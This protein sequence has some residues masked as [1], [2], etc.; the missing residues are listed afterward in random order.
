MACRASVARTVEFRPMGGLNGRSNQCVA[1][2]SDTLVCVPVDCPHRRSS[3]VRGRGGGRERRGGGR[4]SRDA[5]LRCC[6]CVPPPRPG[7][8]ACSSHARRGFRLVERRWTV[9]APACARGDAVWGAPGGSAR[10]APSSVDRVWCCGVGC[11]PARCASAVVAQ[12]PK[13]LGH[14]RRELEGSSLAQ[15]KNSTV[16]R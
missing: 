16:S 11:V 5:A 13:R 15:K 12:A 2:T 4:T 8:C 10:R 3:C 1:M 6:S 14:R 7:A 9:G